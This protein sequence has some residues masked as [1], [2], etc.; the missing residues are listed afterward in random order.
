MDCDDRFGRSFDQLSVGDIVFCRNYIERDAI[1]RLG[2]A[3][4]SQSIKRATHPMVIT[5]KDESSRRLIGVQ[6]T[7]K[8]IGDIDEDKRVYFEQ[9]SKYV[10]GHGGIMLLAGFN[11]VYASSINAS[12]VCA[13]ALSLRVHVG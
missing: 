10:G 12:V 4:N 3:Y 6:M 2:L 1:R 9:S 5:E 8:S 11:R 7:S 13:L